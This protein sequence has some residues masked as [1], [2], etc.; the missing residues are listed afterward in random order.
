[1]GKRTWGQWQL[2]YLQANFSNMEHADIAV[3]I[4]KT[5]NAVRN[6]AYDLLLRKKAMAYS[7]YEKSVIKALYE[8]NIPPPQIA[9][10]L[11]RPLTGI[12]VEARKMGLTDMARPKSEAVLQGLHEA[13]QGRLAFKGVPRGQKREFRQCPG[14]GM[15]FVIGHARSQIYC[16]V[17]CARRAQ[18]TNQVRYSRGKSGKREDLGGQFFRSRY[19]ANYARLLNMFIKSY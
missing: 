19:E 13:A 1:M 12:C 5:R 17:L 3:K 2:D 11:S 9:A 16:T 18:A 8:L 4:G 7:P 14:C 6:K 15:F 10:N